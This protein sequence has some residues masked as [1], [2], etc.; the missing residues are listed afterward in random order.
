MI[1]EFGLPLKSIDTSS[2]S[3]YARMPLSG[4]EA[5]SLNAALTSLL[6]VFLLRIATRSTTETLGVGTRIAKPSSL[7]LRS[8]STSPIATAAPVA[9]GIIDTAAARARRR[10]LCGRRSEEHTSEL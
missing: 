10:Y 8:G 7:P 9:V 1:E 6:V 4:P 5:A 3:E 2:S